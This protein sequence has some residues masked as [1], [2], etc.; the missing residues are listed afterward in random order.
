MRAIKVPPG[1]LRE[2]SCEAL[3]FSALYHSRETKKLQ[4][5]ECESRFLFVRLVPESD[6]DLVG[7]GPL[8]AISF[9]L[10]SV[11]DD[12]HLVAGYLD[13]EV[14]IVDFLALKGIVWCAR[15]RIRV[16]RSTA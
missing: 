5:A 11:H 7:L 9:K 1:L 2:Y 15:Y 3:D 8:C 13:G 16:C 14:V 10:E 6:G 12:A 4:A